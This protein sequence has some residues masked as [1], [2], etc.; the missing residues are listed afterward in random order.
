MAQR[1]KLTRPPLRATQPKAEF[2]RT[3]GL[4]L[5][6]YYPVQQP[7]RAGPQL[8][9]GQQPPAGGRILVL[10]GLCRSATGQPVAGVLVELWHADPLGRYAHA[11]APEQQVVQGF[12]GYGRAVSD[13]TGAFAFRT[14]VPG[15]YVDRNTRRAP[16]LHLQLTG[17]VDRLATQLFLPGQPANAADRWFAMLVRP[18]LLVAR[19]LHA[20]PHSMHL[21]WTAVLNT[22]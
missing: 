14:L 22:G 6:P 18:E 20:T 1:N 17:R 21:G 3:P 9:T 12:S 4:L 15:G 13:E 19:L 8:W 10:E 16:H 2:P 11:S 5:G 7:S